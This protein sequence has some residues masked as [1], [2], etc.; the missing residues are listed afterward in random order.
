MKKE[1]TALEGKIAGLENRKTHCE[2]LLC[3]PQTHKNPP[4]IKE[5]RIEYKSI[6]SEL[7][8]SYTLWTDLS[9]K[10]EETGL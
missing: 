10:L 7:E 9:S 5:L 1:L 6:E 4:A 2:K 8:A 3:D